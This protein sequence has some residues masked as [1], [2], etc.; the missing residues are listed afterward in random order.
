MTNRAPPGGDA[1]LYVPSARRPVTR[2]AFCLASGVTFDTFSLPVKP[3]V[4]NGAVAAFGNI[5][6]LMVDQGTVEANPVAIKA[7]NDLIG[8]TLDL[9]V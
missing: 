6:R 8:T 4:E 2:A 3:N 9:I 5:V 1:P 7:E